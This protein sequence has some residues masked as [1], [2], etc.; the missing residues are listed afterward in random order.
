MSVLRE[1]VIYVCFSFTRDELCIYLYVTEKA[2]FEPLEF[3]NFCLKLL[4]V[5]MVI[6][7]HCML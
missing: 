2:P 4:G 5:W 3:I 1:I 7:F 6:V